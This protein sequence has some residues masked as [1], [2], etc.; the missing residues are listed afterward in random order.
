[1]HTLSLA[2]SISDPYRMMAGRKQAFL[3]TRGHV[4]HIQQWVSAIGAFDCHRGRVIYLEGTKEGT[5]THY[6]GHLV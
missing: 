3:H 2:L 6:Q 1:M 5:V 4:I